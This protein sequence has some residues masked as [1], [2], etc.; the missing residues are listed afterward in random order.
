MEHLFDFVG[1][2]AFWIG[3][4]QIIWIDLI[5]SGDNALVIALACRNLPPE[6]RK[7]GVILGTAAAVILRI[8]FATII[9]Y[10]LDVPFLKL[11]GAALLLW[12]AIKLM[13]PEE[14]EDGHGSGGGSSLWSAVRTVVIADAVMSLDNV[15]AVAAAAHSAATGA[16]ETGL[17][18]EAVEAG[19]VFLLALGIAISIP[20]M[21]IGSSMMIWLLDRFPWLMIL[22]GALLGWIAGGL[23]VHDPVSA[24]WLE[25]NMPWL[26]SAAPF[27]GAGL[28]V[29][30]SVWLM[31]RERPTKRA[32]VLDMG[33]PGS[34]RDT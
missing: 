11:I 23:A 13:I 12:I 2:H 20:L 14:G 22:G 25:A 7:W 24:P 28:V 32:E 3:L 8:L 19:S 9:V 33:D 26:V 18:P 34:G 4:V 17:S 21:V 6:Q 30:A 10:V 29:A 1:T 27:I 15:M 16:G 31:R 5:L